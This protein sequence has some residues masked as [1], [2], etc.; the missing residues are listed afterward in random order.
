MCSLHF[1]ERAGQ[2]EKQQP[3]QEHWRLQSGWGLDCETLCKMRKQ[4]L[5]LEV[6]G[7]GEKK[8]NNSNKN[9]GSSVSPFHFFNKDLKFV[10]NGK[11]RKKSKSLKNHKRKRTAATVNGWP[12]FSSTRKSLSSTLII[13][14]LVFHSDLVAV[15]KCLLCPKCLRGMGHFLVYG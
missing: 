8:L 2:R 12:E 3:R 6:G 15:R 7:G 13:K 9:F 5:L 10:E 11:K 4:I 14:I 1:P